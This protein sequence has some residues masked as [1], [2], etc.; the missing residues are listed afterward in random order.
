MAAA[1][2]LPPI[3]SRLLTVVVF[4]FA[5]LST[6][7]EEDGD[8]KDYEP[9][10]MIPITSYDDFQEQVEDIVNGSSESAS[11]YPVVQFHVSWCEHCKASMPELDKAASQ[12]L[13]IAHDKGGFPVPP[14]FF[15]VQCDKASRAITRLC[16]KHVGTHFPMVIVFR[17]QRIYKF[18]NRPRTQR[19]YFLWMRRVIRPFLMGVGSM[20]DVQGWKE[21]NFVLKA[22]PSDGEYIKMWSNIAAK[23]VHLEEYSFTFLDSSTGGGSGDAEVFMFAPPSAGLSPLPFT[24]DLDD[25]DSISRLEAWIDTN[26]FPSVGGLASPLE[27]H[28]YQESNRKIVLLV[29]G[30]GKAG[31]QARK[32]FGQFVKTERPSC[33]FIFVSVD[34]SQESDKEALEVHFPLLAPNLATYP[35]IFGFIGK[36]Y[37]EDPKLNDIK[38]LRVDALEALFADPGARQDKT[39]LGWAKEKKKV[40][41][42]FA[43]KNVAN[44]VLAVAMPLLILAILH[45][46]GKMLLE[47]L[48]SDDESDE[49][50]ENGDS[51]KAKAKAKDKKKA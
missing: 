14:K 22:K 27:L 4:G 42:R 30:G 24:G 13:D 15:S 1:R 46:I 39:W 8:D 2:P 17:E 29:H 18:V 28:R 33:N 9:V 40:Y 11:Y 19:V 16:D 21:P 7:R 25:D 35:Q 34:A 26:R 37:Y 20:S 6:A 47:S 51:K 31:T 12:I 44:T 38:N 45:T 48:S 50:D 3:A 10:N 36:S 41:M 49:K 23:P 5:V 43:T 32:D